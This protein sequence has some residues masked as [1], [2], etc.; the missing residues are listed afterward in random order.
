MHREKKKPFYTGCLLNA[1]NL[2][3]S[4]GSRPEEDTNTCTSTT[5]IRN[6]LRQEK[7]FFLYC[8]G[9]SRPEEAGSRWQAFLL[10][11]TSA[12]VLYTPQL[13]AMPYAMD[14][15]AMPYAMDVLSSVRRTGGACHEACFEDSHYYNTEAKHILKL[16]THTHVILTLDM[17]NEHFWFDHVIHCAT[18]PTVNYYP[19]HTKKTNR[20]F[21]P[22]LTPKWAFVPPRYI[23]SKP[24]LGKL[25]GT[26]YV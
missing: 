3:L 24:V 6:P 15:N 10:Q 21:C 4:G 13:N 9:S 14:L 17:L 25:I 23:S 12:I 2:H 16:D 18:T 11:G 19:R 20:Q 8:G 5:Y 1:S 7:Q 22:R 26:T